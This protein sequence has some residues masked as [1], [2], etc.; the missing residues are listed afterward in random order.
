MIDPAAKRVYIYRPGAAVECP[1]D[2]ETVAG[3][4]ALPGFVLSPREIW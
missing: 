3:D 1:K 2:P 4:P